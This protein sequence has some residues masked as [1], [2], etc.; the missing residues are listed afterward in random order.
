MHYLT[1]CCIAKDENA[2][3]AEWAAYH[4]L[5]GAE[6][7]V[8]YDNGSATS[9]ART[10]EPLSRR[11]DIVVY[12]M[13]G[14]ARQMAAYAH[15]L[16]QHGPDSQWMA[17]IDVDE[18]L[19]PKGEDD[20]RVLLSEYEAHAGLGVNWVMFGSSGHEAPPELVIESFTKR[21]PY[22]FPTNHHIKSIVRPRYVKGPLSPHHFAYAPG[23]YCVNEQGFP[24]P[25][26]YGP[27]H[28]ARLQLN[29]YFFRSRQE[30]AEKIARG[31][32]DMTTD[33]FKHSLSDFESQLGYCTE[34]DTEIARFGPD[35]RA[36]LHGGAL[37]APATTDFARDSE[38]VAL[39]LSRGR[40]DLAE[41]L[42]RAFPVAYNDQSAAWSLR[43]LV[44]ARVGRHAEAREALAASLRLEQTVENL[45]NLVRI[46]LLAG[47]ADEARRTARYLWW[48]LHN[49]DAGLRDECAAILQEIRPLLK[50]GAR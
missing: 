28:N 49:V 9:L 12:D 42:S 16:E 44:L 11:I 8:V 26:P 1:L 24:L 4:A 7:I 33:Q 19:L 46:R 21:A 5:R 18:F 35:V 3:I 48:R 40:I 30:F 2:R 27:H 15:C 50:E 32:G 10:L 6:K 47:E 36:V 37:P 20:L 25:G 29:H 17:F 43:G 13:S 41:T 45:A 39:L 34:E 14:P 23:R 31:R 22:A 38:K